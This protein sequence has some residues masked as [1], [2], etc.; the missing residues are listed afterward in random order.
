MN[1]KRR[2]IINKFEII[3]LDSIGR[4]GGGV[5][6]ENS[7]TT[8]TAL[9][10]S[11]EALPRSVGEYAYRKRL[12]EREKERDMTRLAATHW[13]ETQGNQTE[14]RGP[15]EECHSTQT[16]SDPT[17]PFSIHK[18]TSFVVL[19]LFSFLLLLLLPSSHLQFFPRNGIFRH[20]FRPYL[21][22]YWFILT[23]DRRV[24][25]FCIVC[26]VQGAILSEK[27]TSSPEFRWKWHF[28]VLCST[29]LDSILV[30]SWWVGFFYGSC[31]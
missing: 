21:T 8:Y 25:V 14:L 17:I 27:F 4:P 18:P 19:L 31:D 1:N 15:L 22:P 7:R 10:C 9:R 6:K 23:F 26:D 24:V 16:I 20:C 13:R 29:I 30:S 28:P 3:Y 12:R 5:L 2:P 11:T